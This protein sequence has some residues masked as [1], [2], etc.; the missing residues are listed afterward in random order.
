MSLAAGRGDHL[1]GGI[2]VGFAI[3]TDGGDGSC[4]EGGRRLGWGGMSGGYRPMKT[5]RYAGMS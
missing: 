1:C 4:G 3:P 5:M 2:D